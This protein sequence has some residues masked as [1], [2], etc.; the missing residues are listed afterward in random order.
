MNSTADYTD[1][2]LQ[3]TL[4]TLE[5][6][7][8]FYLCFLSFSTVMLNGL[9][10]VTIYKDPLKCLRSPSACFIAGLTSSNFLTGFI[11]EPMFAGL[12]IWHYS[13]AE[14]GSFYGVARVAEVIAF[15]TINASLLIIL[16][17]AVSQYIA[18]THSGLYDRIV[19]RNKAKLGI[20]CIFA[21]SLLFS[22]LPEIGAMDL[23]TFYE[24]DMYLHTT[25]ISVLLVGIYGAM[26]CKF[27]QLW[28][29]SREADV[30]QESE[31]NRQQRERE[32]TKTTFILTLFLIV[33]VWPYTV[34]SYVWYYK[35]L[36]SYYDSVRIFIAFLICQNILFLK[37]AWDPLIFAWRLK[38]YR[39]S[40]V[41]MFGAVCKCG[42]RN[43]LPTVAYQRQDSQ[44][45][46]ED[47]E[48][49][50]VVWRRMLY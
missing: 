24:V 10:L 7:T 32:F 3:H 48:I 43:A 6:I 33:T 17:L 12:Y 21:Y 5:I 1:Y 25:L 23:W 39:K 20:I 45:I 46:D 29:T 50:V 42:E 18:V 16:A 30:S 36:N 31:Q 28:G 49:S 9:V 19:S 37:F 41:F 40:F 8:F 47:I 11:V 4:H 27:R 44:A 35:S 2:G 26:Y 34:M 14:A 13:G 38:K 22:V 15:V